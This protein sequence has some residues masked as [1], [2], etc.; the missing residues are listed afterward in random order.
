[1]ASGC[2]VIAKNIDNNKE[3]IDDKINGYYNN[4]EDLTTLVRKLISGN[5]DLECVSKVQLKMVNNSLESLKTKNRRSKKTR[6]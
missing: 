6:H 4:K 1:M 2:I 5:I 3:I